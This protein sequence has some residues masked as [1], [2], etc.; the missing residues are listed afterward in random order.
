MNK[1]AGSEGNRVATLI[2]SNKSKW[3]IADVDLE[4]SAEAVSLC[5]ESVKKTLGKFISGFML[6]SAGVKNLVVS[7]SV[8]QDLVG[9]LD[10]LEFLLTSLKEVN[11]TGFETLNGEGDTKYVSCKVV[12]ELDTPFKLKDVVRSSAFAF[13]RAKSLLQEESDDEDFYEF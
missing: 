8:H 9:E 6:I 12:L 11:A 7:V 13:L 1:K 5:A 10:A 4:D 2:K 3:Y